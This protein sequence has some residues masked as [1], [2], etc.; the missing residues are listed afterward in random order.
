[1]SGRSRKKQYEEVD[2]VFVTGMLVLTYSQS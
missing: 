2:S 1:M